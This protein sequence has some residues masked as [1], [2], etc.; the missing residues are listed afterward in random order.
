MTYVISEEAFQRIVSRRTREEQTADADAETRERFVK[1]LRNLKGRIT[2][3]LRAVARSKEW[4]SVQL[5]RDAK[6]RETVVRLVPS[7]H[8]EPSPT[9]FG[10]WCLQCPKVRERVAFVGDIA[11]ADIQAIALVAV[12]KHHFPFAVPEVDCIV[13]GVGADVKSLVGYLAKDGLILGMGIGPQ[14]SEIVSTPTGRF[15]RMRL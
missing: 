9:E 1:A 6:F 11:I 4:L 14:G 10:K 5:T 15:F 2:P 3:A 8:M 12:A 7:R 13:A